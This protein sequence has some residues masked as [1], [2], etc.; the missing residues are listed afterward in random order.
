[1]LS[2]KLLLS[3]SGEIYFF[4]VVNTCACKTNKVVLVFVTLSNLV[5]EDDAG[6]TLYRP[7]SGILVSSISILRESFEHWWRTDN[8]LASYSTG[9]LVV[10]D[11]LSYCSSPQWSL[12][13]SV[14]NRFHKKWQ[15][16]LIHSFW[17]LS[18]FCFI[19]ELEDKRKHIC[20]IIYSVIVQCSLLIVYIKCY[21]ILKDF[22][23]DDNK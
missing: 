11:I 13:Y 5:Y 1:M 9:F 18:C 19:L 15:S 17:E 10:V 14:M 20:C 22:S 3:V 12:N 23:C 2:L 21:K 16:F 4:F 6:H 8:T 7:L